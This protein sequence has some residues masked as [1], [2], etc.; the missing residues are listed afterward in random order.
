MPT[1]NRIHKNWKVPVSGALLLATAV[2]AQ[3]DFQTSLN[4][5]NRVTLS[6]R[7][8]VN[9]S[10]RFKGTAS[11]AFPTSLTGLSTAGSRRTPNGAPYNYDDGYVFTDISGNA[12]NQTWYWGYDNS[13]QVNT[14]NHTISFDR[15]TT[16]A[17]GRIPGDVGGNESDD[18]S[19]LGAELTYNYEI[20]Q[21]ADW[22]HLRYGLEAAINY[23][24]VDFS[25]SASY[26]TKFGVTHITD[27]Y[28]YTPGTT[29][30]GYEVPGELPYQG[31][32]QGPNFLLNVPPVS[33]VSTMLS[34]ATFLIQQKFNGNLWGFRLGPYLE[35]PL[36]E[37]WSAHLS[38]GLAVGLLDADVSWQETFAMPGGAGSVSRT[39]GGSD[40]GLLWGGY[41]GLQAQYQFNDR[42]G[43]EAGVQLQDLGVYDHNFGGRTAE[44][45]L[46]KSV[47]L[48]AGISF[49]F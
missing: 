19:H 37:H 15:T 34:S 25:S 24:P 20:G 43:V 22:H 26:S 39:S 12:G 35:L 38:G 42:W 5:T 13:S 46:S 8:G 6:L 1:M 14:A 40:M 10:G 36:S 31:T 16:I 2:S 49:S 27:I 33:S 41:I 48:H 17:P 32:F 29:P 28:S 44:L 9:F 23:M 30:P 21:K 3:Q 47:F 4:S 11:I 7:Y 45:D 18:S